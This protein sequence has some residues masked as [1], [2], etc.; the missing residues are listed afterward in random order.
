MTSGLELDAF[1]REA[2][3]LTQALAGLSEDDWGLPTRCE[4]WTV[5]ELLGHVRV[6]IGWLP[7][8]LA[9]AEPEQADVSAVE[10][11]RP[12]ERFAAATN[13]ARIGL[14]QD[15]AAKQAGGAALVQDFTAACHRVDQLCRAER[16]GRVVL[17]RHGDAMLLSDFLVTRVVEVAVHGLDL[18]DALRRAPWLTRQAADTVAE[19]LLGPEWTIALHELGWDRLEFIRKATGRRA[20]EP[21]DITRVERLGIRW[22]TLG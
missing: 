5:R 18:A 15:Y 2:T 3:A 14:A 17:T 4:P 12:D 13:V 20:L 16:A 1:R 6:A 11:Y 8:M 9:A 22:L 10:Y 21:A 19:L 7:G